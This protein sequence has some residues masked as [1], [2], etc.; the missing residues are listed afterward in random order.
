MSAGGRLVVRPQQQQ[1]P[2]ENLVEGE[3]DAED[4]D[5]LLTSKNRS[6]S[7]GVLPR[8]ALKAAHGDHVGYHYG[9]GYGSYDRY[10]LNFNKIINEIDKCYDVH[11]R[12]CIFFNSTQIRIYSYCIYSSIASDIT[13]L[14]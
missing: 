14:I 5:A 7:E 6:K 12:A 3:V 8:A 11:N 1:G 13:S 10:I 9:H 2:V 4:F